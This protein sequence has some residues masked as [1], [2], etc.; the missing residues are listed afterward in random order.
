MWSYVRNLRSKAFAWISAGI[1]GFAAVA[2]AI[3]LG[4]FEGQAKVEI[5]AIAPGQSLDAGK[6]LIKPLKAWFTDQKIFMLTPK[7][8]QKALVLEAELMNRT[9]QSD[10]DYYE[11][12]QLPPDIM[13]KAEKPMFFLARDESVMPSLQPGMPERMVYVWIVP[14]DIVPKDSLDFS[15]EA[16]TFK[17]RNN[18]TGEPGWWGKYTAG[19]VNLPLQPGQ[20]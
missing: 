7:A 14:A 10:K 8:G 5:P 9:A 1:G 4:V 13:A 11:V 16:E 19:T 6:W 20:G 17:L 18:L 12:F 2:V 3:G 15:I